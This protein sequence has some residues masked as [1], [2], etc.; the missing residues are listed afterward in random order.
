M[1]VSLSL[2]LDFRI[3]AEFFNQKVTKPQELGGKLSENLTDG[4]EKRR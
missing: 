3:F 2:E 1:S 4:S